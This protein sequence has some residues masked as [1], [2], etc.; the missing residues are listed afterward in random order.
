MKDFEE[1]VRDLRIDCSEMRIKTCIQKQVNLLEAL[2]RRYPRVKRKT[3]GAISNQ[4][5]SWPHEEVR[6]AFK[7]LYTFTCDYP[8]IRHAGTQENALRAIDM[9]DLVAMS[10]LLAGFIPYLSS[11]LN[12]DAVY[13]G[14]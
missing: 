7:S 4:I 12:L 9:R 3:L 1:S 11:E 10:I 5:A 8:G 13:R 6:S 2:G 14:E